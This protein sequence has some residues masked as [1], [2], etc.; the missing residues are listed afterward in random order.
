MKK[1]LRTVIIII[2][3]ACCAVSVAAAVGIVQLNNDPESGVTEPCSGGYDC[4]LEKIHFYTDGDE[5]TDVDDQNELER[6]VY[7]I[8]DRQNYYGEVVVTVQFKSNIEQESEYRSIKNTE[9]KTAEDA[10]EYRARL[11]AFSK[12]YHRD[13]IESNVILISCIPYSAIEPIEYS[14]FVRLTVNAHDLTADCL[15]LASGCEN[16]VSIAIGYD[17]PP[18]QDASWDEALSATNAYEVA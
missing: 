8:H 13:I 10:R 2:L 7:L 15:L 14:P 12:E 9:I 17:I 6:A 16:I 1:T 4:S 3:A 11:N 5:L 18:E